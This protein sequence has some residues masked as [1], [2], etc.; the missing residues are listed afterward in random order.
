MIDK[1]NCA[2]GT[3][4]GRGVGYSTFSG[5][6]NGKVVTTHERYNT[7]SYTSESVTTA[8]TDSKGRLVLSGTF[9]DSN[10]THGKNSGTRIS[11]PS[12]NICGSKKVELLGIVNQ[13]ACKGRTRTS[14]HLNVAPIADK[15]VTVSGA[16]GTHVTRTAE[17]G[18]YKLLVKK[19]R[20]TIRVGAGRRGTVDPTS[21]SL[22]ARASVGHLNFTVCKAPK[23]YH[24]KA[25]RCDLVEIDGRVGESIGTPAGY[26]YADATVSVEGDQATTDERGHY[27]LFAPKGT[28]TV[29]ASDPTGAPLP[30]NSIQVHATHTA[31]DAPTIRLLPKF[32]LKS[33]SATLIVFQAAGVSPKQAGVR[34][35]FQGPREEGCD[36]P[37]NPS[38]PVYVSHNVTI[39]V[40]T[41]FNG[42]FCPGTFVATLIGFDN[43]A[44]P[45]TKPVRFTVP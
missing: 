42:R 7:G 40:T 41:A 8:S 6:I 32:G 5:T 34:V 43:M 38:L 2:A 3:F 17:D 26:P 28:H 4:S 25:P 11:K 10:G 24:G 33:V 1:E 13:L 29:T 35:S 21:R 36:F 12:G 44:L 14:C 30:S 22:V 19:G 9:H 20:Q 15:M 27:T 18:S 23:G 16:G 39:R 45:G 37:N 31:N